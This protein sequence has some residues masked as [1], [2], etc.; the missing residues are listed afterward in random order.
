ML[1][2][3][4]RV[5]IG[6]LVAVCLQVAMASEPLRRE[7][8]TQLSEMACKSTTETGMQTEVADPL[9]TVWL[10]SNTDPVIR[11]EVPFAKIQERSP[12]LADYF[13][14]YAHSATPTLAMDAFYSDKDVS[15]IQRYL[16][17]GLQDGEA[18]TYG[19]KRFLEQLQTNN[20][21][22]FQV[23]TLQSA[24]NR[25]NGKPAFS[26]PLSAG[27][28]QKS[29]YFQQKMRLPDGTLR[30]TYTVP[31]TDPKSLHLFTYLLFW[32][33][34]SNPFYVRDQFTDSVR[35][36][37]HPM[38][39]SYCL[40]FPYKKLQQLSMILRGIDRNKVP[41]E[42]TSVF[43]VP[44]L[45]AS[46]YGQIE[47]S[48]VRTF[49]NQG[50]CSQVLT[51][52]FKPYQDDPAIV[53]KSTPLMTDTRAFA[54][55]GPD[56]EEVCKAYLDKAYE[57]WKKKVLFVRPKEVYLG[58][59]VV[60]TSKKSLKPKG[61]TMEERRSTYLAFYRA[62]TLAVDGTVRREAWQ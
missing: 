43:W 42:N 38:I 56:P 32:G 51:A 1:H 36:G 44:F 20:P 19:T 39:E 28:V 23:I 26:C 27:T 12:V 4:F 11:Y 30:E 41:W 45:E 35:H 6:G 17:F 52:S 10:Q 33:H 34:F 2:I 50:T 14:L 21:K 8:S 40:P 3:L 49:S 9:N 48:I 5:E 7:A 37:L 55:A 60:K 24:Y 13:R 18:L 29:A 57:T 58:H 62:A 22:D 31:G 47:E 53:P 15:Q 25:S 46:K 16:V 61:A 54:P 59:F